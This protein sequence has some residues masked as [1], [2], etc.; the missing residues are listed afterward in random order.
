MLRPG[1]VQG[2][3][4]RSVLILEVLKV[5]RNRPELREVQDVTRDV[6]EKEGGDRVKGEMSYS[7]VLHMILTLR[8][9]HEVEDSSNQNG[10]QGRSNETNLLNLHCH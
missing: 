6:L 9:T 10:E 5:V 4:L 3:F 8:F 1:S 2:S 7:S